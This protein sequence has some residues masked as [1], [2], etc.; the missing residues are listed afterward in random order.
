METMTLDESV[1][2]L[3]PHAK[4]IAASLSPTLR[5]HLG[6]MFE[7]LAHRTYAA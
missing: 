2:R 6:D 5:A 7:A 3:E 4:A 1:R